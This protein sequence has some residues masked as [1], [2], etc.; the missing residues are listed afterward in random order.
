MLG[1]MI[2]FSYYS[3][4]IPP[5]LILLFYLAECPYIDLLVWVLHFLISP[6]LYLKRNRGIFKNF[7]LTWLTPILFFLFGSSL[8]GSL[9]TS[10]FNKI[11]SL[12]SV[13][14]N[15]GITFLVRALCFP[16]PHE[17]NIDCVTGLW[18]LFVWGKELELLFYASPLSVSLSFTFLRLF[19]Y[20]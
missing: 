16:S 20:T 2:H 6:R 11:Q 19:L 5:P 15:N 8:I 9:L 17:E 14:L 7:T 10:S 18:N 4:I 12:I 1:W 3:C 13:A